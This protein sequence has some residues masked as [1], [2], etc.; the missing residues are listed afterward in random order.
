MAMTT[1]NSISVKPRGRG[2]GSR[3]ER[4][5]QGRRFLF[6]FRARPSVVQLDVQ[7]V[8]LGLHLEDDLPGPLALRRVGV[9]QADR[10][11]VAADAG[12]V[13]RLVGTEDVVP[14]G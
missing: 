2:R 4:P 1:S 3:M 12:A 8:V 11:A 5:P 13:E 9:V 10:D 6:T 7:G 14:L